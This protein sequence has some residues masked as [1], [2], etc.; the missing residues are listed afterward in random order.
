RGPDPDSPPERPKFLECRD[1]PTEGLE[2]RVQAT[3][4]RQEPMSASMPLISALPES[5][6]L[7]KTTA[8][9]P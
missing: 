3:T 2:Q 1:H 4:V 7:M 9:A 8:P 5:M 6:K